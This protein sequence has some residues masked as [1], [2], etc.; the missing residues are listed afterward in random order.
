MKTKII[1]LIFSVFITLSSFAQ[2]EYIGTIKMFAGNFAPRGYLFCDGRVLPISQYT[3][4]FSIL[5]TMY[6][7]NGVTTF[8]LPDLR[9]RV[10][11]QAGAGPELSNYALGQRGGEERTSLTIANLP[12]HMHSIAPLG[13]EQEGNTHLP[14]DAY[15]ANTKLLDKE[16]YKPATGEIPATKSMKTIQT[17]VAGSSQ[18][19][20][21]MQPYLT[22]NYIICVEGIY[23]SRW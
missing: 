16:Y 3:A 13:V 22:V 20:N 2:E 23:P 19:V 18:P 6:G 17:G 14:T 12:Q 5:G 9:G 1:T 7:G 8:A 15:P 4:L 11:I 21:N 10:P